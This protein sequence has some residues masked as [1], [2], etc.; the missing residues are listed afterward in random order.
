M[1]ALTPACGTEMDAVEI[2]RAHYEPGTPLYLLLLDHS[3]R[4][5]DKALAVAQRAPHLAPDLRFIEQAAMLH[6]IGIRETAARRIH[7][8]GTLPYLCHGVV[9]AE[10]LNACGLARHALVCERHVGVGFS[11]EEIVEH[12]LP[13][14]PR[15]M[16][17]VSPEETIV[18]YAD[19]FFSKNR[20]N[21]ELSPGEVLNELG[22]F[23]ASRAARFRQWH[24]EFTGERLDD[25]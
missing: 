21:R 17:P 20:P 11:R 9:G 13:L 3:R 12:H 24:F 4:V 19:K 2:L 23:G 10:M 7:C 16:L 1:S 15:D 18:C 22:R 5:R 6:D 14:P 8:R 25:A